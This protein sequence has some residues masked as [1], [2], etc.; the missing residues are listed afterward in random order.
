MTEKD[1]ILNNNSG[2]IPDGFYSIVKV[3]NV[4]NPVEELNTFK[5]TIINYS[6]FG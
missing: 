6:F 2:Q 3:K 5:Q 1:R 4:S